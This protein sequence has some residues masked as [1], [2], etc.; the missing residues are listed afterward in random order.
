MKTLILILSLLG[1][2][3]AL[4]GEFFCNEE[5]AQLKDKSYYACGIGESPSEDR[6]RASALDHAKYEFASFCEGNSKCNNK[7]LAFEPTRNLCKKVGIIY[8]CYRMVV[9][10]ME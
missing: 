3:M 7:N 9:F 10:T 8:K 4:A 6:A 2:N 5:A 1:S